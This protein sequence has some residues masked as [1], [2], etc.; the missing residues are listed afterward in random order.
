MLHLCANVKQ[1][2]K[3]SAVTLKPV[4]IFSHPATSLYSGGSLTIA[5]WLYLSSGALPPPTELLPDVIT[6]M[7]NTAFY[8]KNGLQSERTPKQF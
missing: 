3:V 6:G 7:Q 2:S 1:V 8:Q 4:V 5:S